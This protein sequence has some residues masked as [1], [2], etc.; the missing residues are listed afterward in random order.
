MSGKSNRRTSGDGVSTFRDTV[1][2]HDM[3]TPAFDASSL[4]KIADPI[5][6]VILLDRNTPTEGEAFRALCAGVG[7]RR[8]AMN[9]PRCA[10][11]GTMHAS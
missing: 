11:A 9:R 10:P 4:S 3:A 5:P 1:L 2:A 8:Y 6:H 7:A